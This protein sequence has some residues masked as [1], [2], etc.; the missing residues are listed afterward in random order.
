MK[1]LDEYGYSKSYI[2]KIKEARNLIL[3]HRDNPM[4]ES[5]EDLY[6]KVVVPKYSKRTRDEYR[7]TIGHI[8]SYVE[9]GIFLGAGGKVRG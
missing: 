4:V 2:R 7:C 5:Y 9:K 3:K 8:Y 6:H 1:L